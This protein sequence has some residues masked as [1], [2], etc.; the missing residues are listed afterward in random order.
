MPP[1]LDVHTYEHQ[2]EEV[3]GELDHLRDEECMLRG[4]IVAASAIE[5]AIMQYEGRVH[6]DQLE[7][8]LGLTSA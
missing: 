5:S 7:S 1:G 2:L 3:L 8:D 4:K 6:Q